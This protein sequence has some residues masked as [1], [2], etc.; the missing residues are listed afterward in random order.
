MGKHGSPFC[1][2]TGTL[3]DD[4]W[5]FFFHPNLPENNIMF[6][7]ECTAINLKLSFKAAPFTSELT[8]VVSVVPTVEHNLIWE[9]QKDMLQM[10]CVVIHDGI[11]SHIMS[12]LCM[13]AMNARRF[14]ELIEELTKFLEIMMGSR[15][16]RNQQFIGSD[17]FLHLVLVL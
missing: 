8:L 1:C 14:L 10:T 13:L 4:T 2:V 16:H 9:A 3:E 6:S 12:D 5:W 7:L 11:V 17:C 15:W